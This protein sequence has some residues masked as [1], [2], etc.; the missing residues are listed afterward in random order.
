[1]STDEIAIAAQKIQAR[2][3]KLKQDRDFPQ[4]AKLITYSFQ[5]ITQ[6]YNKQIFGYLPQIFREV[7]IFLERDYIQR[8]EIFIGEPVIYKI[9]YPNNIQLYNLNYFYVFCYLKEDSPELNVHFQSAHPNYRQLSTADYNLQSGKIEFEGCISGFKN[10]RSLISVSD[11]GHSIPGYTSSFYVGSPQLNFTKL[12]SEVLESIINSANLKTTNTLLIGSSAGTFGALLSSTYFSQKI[13][14]LAVNSQINIQYRKDIIKLFTGIDRPQE[15]IEK[16][17]MQV[18]CLYRFRQQLNSIPNI[19]ILAN[20][21]DNLYSRNFQFYNLYINTHTKAGI[22]NQSVFDSYY[23]V[24][25]HG[26][27]EPNSLK[28]KIRIARE[29]LTMRS[30]I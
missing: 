15:L 12:I 20:V 3:Q 6:Q 11:P 22:D 10:N 8:Q 5:A 4:I 18:S 16:F 21:N 23:G 14:V 25:G 13:N 28:A 24:D 7:E 29:V 27:P 19:Y 9:Y 30:R 26:R 2:F 1:M 17:G